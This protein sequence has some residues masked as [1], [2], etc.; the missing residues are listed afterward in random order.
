MVL[1]PR[2]VLLRWTKLQRR[3][4]FTRKE[5]DGRL[6]GRLKVQTIQILGGDIGFCL[7]VLLVNGVTGSGWTYPYDCIRSKGKQ[8]LWSR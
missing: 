2:G 5:M 3:R 8:N 7:F 4:T 1:E 6:N